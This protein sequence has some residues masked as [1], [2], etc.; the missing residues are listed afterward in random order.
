[1]CCIVL[2]VSYCCC[3]F[4]F[5]KLNQEPVQDPVQGPE[6]SDNGSCVMMIITF[7]LGL[8]FSL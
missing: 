8:L 3:F 4:H 5:S 6:R 2:R 1:M 7:N